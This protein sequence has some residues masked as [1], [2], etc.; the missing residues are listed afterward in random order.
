M[1]APLLWKGVL[2]LV[3]IRKDEHSKTQVARVLN[4]KDSRFPEAIFKEIAPNCFEDELTG[5]LFKVLD[6]AMVSL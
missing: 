6:G 5:D 1:I 3:Q 2:K 4:A